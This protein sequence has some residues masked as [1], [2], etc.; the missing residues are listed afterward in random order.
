VRAGWL[1]AAAIICA[2]PPVLADT[3]SSSVFVTPVTS[4]QSYP[5]VAANSEGWFDAGGFCKVVDVGDLSALSPNA[6]GVPVFIPGPAAQWEN[7]RT[8]AGTDYNGQLT[9]TTCCRPASQII[10]LCATGTNPQSVSLQYGKYGEVDPIAA[11]CTDSFGSTY[12]ESVN[13]TCQG[14]TGTPSVDNG[15]DGQATWQAGTINDTCAPNA[16]TTACN[17]TCPSGVGTTSTYDSCGNLAGSTSCTVPCGPECPAVTVTWNDWSTGLACTGTFPATPV[18]AGQDGYG[19]TTAEAIQT[20]SVANGYVSGSTYDD[21]QVSPGGSPV[22]AGAYGRKGG[23][24]SSE[25]PTCSPNYCPTEVTWTVGAYTCTGQTLTQLLP[26]QNGTAYTVASDPE[27]NGALTVG[28]TAPVTCGANFTLTV[29]PGA[30]CGPGQCVP[31][32]SIVQE[33]CISN[34]DDMVWDSCGK[35]T[36]VGT[37]GSCAGTCPAVANGT[38]S[39]YPGCVITCNS[40]YTLSGGACVASGGGTTPPTGPTYCAPGTVYSSCTLQMYNCRDNPSAVYDDCANECGPNNTNPTGVSN[41]T[42]LY[43]PACGNGSQCQYGTSACYTNTQFTAGEITS[44]VCNNADH[45]ATCPT[46]YGQTCP[47]APCP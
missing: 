34:C 2:P 30:T 45:T 9:L 12:T 37:C 44:Y 11:S 23:R 46:T 22:W 13:I 10:T 35:Q 42:W 28:G 38:T 19:D 31:D 6:T 32:G 1:I 18:V 39:A 29:D 4:G 3:P 36:Y 24:P 27:Q 21:C 43:P 7:Y 14:T 8:L 41:S 33:D 26:G 16:Y 15:P 17:A 5:E 20:A 47:N 40:G 25:W